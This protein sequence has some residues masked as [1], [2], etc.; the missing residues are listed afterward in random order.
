MLRR[1]Q[2]ESDDIGCFAFELRVIAGHVALQPVWPQ[3]GLR[4]NT[5]HGG[6]ANAQF[7]GQFAARPMRAAVAG[8]LLCAPDHSSLH[9]WCRPP[10]LGSLMTSLQAF[11]AMLLESDLPLGHGRRTRAQ[12]LLDLAICQAIGERQDEAGAEHITGGKTSRL[13]PIAQFLAL[14]ITEFEQSL[15]ISHII[16]TLQVCCMYHWDG[17][18]GTVIDGASIPQPL[19]SFMGGPYEGKYLAASV[20]HDYYCSTRLEPWR[21]VHRMFYEA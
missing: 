14:F 5:L 8:F 6:F 15:I 10:R 19:W 17:I 11:D 3:F 1:I 7:L 9:R 20:V 2:I 16:K 4:Q 18:L 21:D 13:C 12:R